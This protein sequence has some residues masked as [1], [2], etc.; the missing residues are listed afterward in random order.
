MNKDRVLERHVFIFN[1]KDNGGEQVSFVT[2][3]RHNG[4][5][6]GVYYDQEISLQSYCNTATIHLLGAAISPDMLRKLANELDAATIRA[7]QKTL[8][9]GFLESE[10]GDE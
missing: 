9:K 1:D 5:P 3:I 10:T 6:E 7:K 4:D 2:D 8:E